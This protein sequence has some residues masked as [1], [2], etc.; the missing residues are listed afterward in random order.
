AG[1]KLAAPASSAPRWMSDLI[2]AFALA[3]IAVIRAFEIGWSINWSIASSSDSS[4]TSIVRRT[5]MKLSGA[6]D[7]GYSA[8]RL[9]HTRSPVPNALKTVTIPAAFRLLVSDDA[10]RIEA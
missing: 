1:L 3:R 7:A 4:I 8:L 2:N 6:V 10:S 9:P 5:E